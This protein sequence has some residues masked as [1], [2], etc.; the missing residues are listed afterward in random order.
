VCSD[1]S[2]TFIRSISLARTIQPDIIINV[3]T[4]SCKV[5]VILVGNFLDRFSNSL[6]YQISLKSLQW[7]PSCSMRTDGRT[8]MTKLTVAFR[9][10]ANAPKKGNVWQKKKSY[11]SGS[12]NMKRESLSWE[13]F[14]CKFTEKFIISIFNSA[15]IQRCVFA[16]VVTD[17]SENHTVLRLRKYNSR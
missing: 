5:P 1:F 8:D 6:K 7:E 11:I 15:G 16:R 12:Q 9:N 13:R 14:V 17:V 4:S 3:K 10:F 2:T